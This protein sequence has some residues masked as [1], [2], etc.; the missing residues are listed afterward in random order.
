MFFVFVFIITAAD[1]GLWHQLG[2]FQYYW[3][4]ELIQIYL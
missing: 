4:D 2:R 3:G 1:V